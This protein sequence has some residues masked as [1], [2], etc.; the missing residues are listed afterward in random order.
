MV[1]TKLE[2]E[3]ILWAG[4]TVVLLFVILLQLNRL[5]KETIEA[6]RQVRIASQKQQRL[7][8]NIN[9]L[10]ATVNDLKV[11][12]QLELERYRKNLGL[13]SEDEIA[14]LKG[15]GLNHPVQDLIAD[16]QKHS[17]II[18]HK[19]ALGGKMGFYS[20][21]N[22]HILGYNWAFA[23]FE[24][25]HIWGNALLRYHVSNSK[26]SWQLLDSHIEQ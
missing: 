16:L 17:D 4:F 6:A 1:K 3:R 9:A 26:I 13:I 8:E 15:K 24:D 7:K 2:R 23:E 11:L 10:N 25:G 19:G 12:R 14:Y 18:P 22:I 21:E 5:K 20:P